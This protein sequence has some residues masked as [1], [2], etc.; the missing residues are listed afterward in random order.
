MKRKKAF[1]NKGGACFV[2]LTVKLK[3][4]KVYNFEGKVLLKHKQ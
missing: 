3:I 4:V 1:A 2:F